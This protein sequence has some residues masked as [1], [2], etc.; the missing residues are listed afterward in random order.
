MGEKGGPQFFSLS[1]FD[2][3]R[4]AALTKGLEVSVVP[5]SE[6]R[7]SEKSRIDSGYF[8]KTAVKLASQV[9]ALPHARLGSM[10]KT[11]RKGIFDIKADTYVESGGVP[12][13]RVGDLRAGLIDPA[14]LTQITAEAHA[15][16]HK[17][18]LQRN[19]IVLSKTAYPAAALV[20]VEKCNV[21]QDTI[22][23]SLSDEGRQRFR[24]AY[25]V[26]YLNSLAGR[27]LMGRL[28]QGNVQEHLGLAEAADL[29]I[30]EFGQTLQSSVARLF[31]EAEDA[32]VQAMSA[33]ARA[34]N[35]LLDALNLQDW[36][37]PNP[38]AYTRSSATVFAAGRLDAEHYQERFYA[39]RSALIEA[40]ALRFIPLASLLTELTNGQTP[41]HHDLT[42]G[43]VLFLAGEHV[44]DF[45]IVLSGKKRV[46]LVHHKG[47]LR[48]TKLSNGDVLFTIK[49]RVGN[50]ALVENLNG[51]TNINQDVALLR[52]SDEL[53][54]WYVLSFL[55]SPFGKM[56]VEQ[57]ATGAINPFLGLENVRRLPIPVFEED[58]MI[59][60][61]ERAHEYVRI[62]QARRGRSQRLIAATKQAVQIALERGEAS[63]LEFISVQEAEDAAAA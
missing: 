20:T 57:L 24:P 47:I 41:L 39:A 55:N 6:V 61:G 17:T 5:L 2:R 50:A 4:F 56:A 1:P 31:E 33:L 11:F 10:S 43:E 18:A 45:E 40:G 35:A 59:E 62:G 42:Q 51:P 29:A 58:K 53:P 37:P 14:G 49:G 28:F 26:A 44:H 22:A 12:F 54:L 27:T 63:A 21:S 32:R 3:D 25:V 36:V 30:P 7:T 38:L 34:E 19:D 46:E 8:R 48:R 52:F 16:E 60:I 13:V 23:I 9:S 15:A